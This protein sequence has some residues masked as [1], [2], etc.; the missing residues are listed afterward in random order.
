MAEEKQK[1]LKIEPGYRVG[2]I[3]VEEATPQRRSGY[4]V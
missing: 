2:K 1:K 3:T 4:T